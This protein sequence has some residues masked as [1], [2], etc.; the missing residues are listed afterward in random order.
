VWRAWPWAKVVG[1][2][3][4]AARLAVLPSNEAASGLGEVRLMELLKAVK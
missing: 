1:A 2:E 4:M 3:R